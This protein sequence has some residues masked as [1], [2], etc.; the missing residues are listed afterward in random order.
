MRAVTRARLALTTAMLSCAPR[1]SVDAPPRTVA[2]RSPRAIPLPARSRVFGSAEHGEDFRAWWNRAVEVFPREAARRFLLAGVAV[3]VTSDGR[4]RVGAWSFDPRVML[5]LRRHG[6]WRFVSPEAVWDA[7]EFTATPRFVAHARR[8]RFGRGAGRVVEVDEGR[9]EGLSLPPGVVLDVAF[10]DDHRGIAL[11]EPGVVLLTDDGGAAWNLATDLTDAVHQVVA[12]DSHRWAVGRSRSFAFDGVVAAPVDTAD[13]P[14]LQGLRETD[15]VIASLEATQ[16][17]AW[18]AISFTDDRRRNVLLWS[19]WRDRSPRLAEYDLVEGRFV[20]AVLPPEDCRVSRYFGADRLYAECERGESTTLYA[21]GADGRW[22]GRLTVRRGEAPA[23]CFVSASGRRVACVGHCAATRDRP[24]GLAVCERD[25]SNRERQRAVG[26]LT[27]PWQSVGYEGESLVFIER[28]RSAQRARVIRGDGPA[29]ALTTSPEAERWVIEEVAPRV[30]RDGR[31]RLV[32]RDVGAERRA[33]VEGRVGERFDPRPAT[34]WS[35][36]D[37]ARSERL[38]SPEGDSVALAPDGTPWVSTATQRAWRPFVSREGHAYLRRFP[39]SRVDGFGP[40]CDE[41]SWTWGLTV[42]GWGEATLAPV[43]GPERNPAATPRAAWISCE[44]GASFSSATRAR[45]RSPWAIT[46]GRLRAAARREREAPSP[47]TAPPSTTTGPR[48]SS[49]RPR[50][51]RRSRSRPRAS[52]PGGRSLRAPSVVASR[53]TA[54][55]YVGS[56]PG[57]SSPA[58]ATR[59]RGCSRALSG[60]SRRRSSG[61]RPPPAQRAPTPR[62]SRP[63]RPVGSA[64]TRSTATSACCASSPTAPRS[65]AAPERSRA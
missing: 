35:A 46:G 30:G 57:G 18:R 16:T 15:P 59:S 44:P 55:L 27:E 40:H 5:P 49:T 53:A 33:V 31:L 7:D 39:F 64:R 8:G 58:T 56:N 42:V 4:S 14:A 65:R 19:T 32:V 9:A 38:C 22:S 2:G 13:V 25:A 63:A 48:C 23:R 24:V 62:S 47:T 26:G 28:R 1:A 6:C 17:A 37:G 41:V 51:G 3:E 10:S 36:E 34:P 11:M 50:R 54:E 12:D 52:S 45:R 20:S 61:P 60:G 21:R 43:L 29:R